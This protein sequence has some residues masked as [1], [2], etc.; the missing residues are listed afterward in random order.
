MEDGQNKHS[1]TFRSRVIVRTFKCLSSMY[2]SSALFHIYGATAGLPR[3]ELYSM[4]AVPQY[5]TSHL[6]EA[7]ST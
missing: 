6:E 2:I 4:D 5:F 3:Q 1:H 7:V